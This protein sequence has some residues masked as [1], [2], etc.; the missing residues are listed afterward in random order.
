MLGRRPAETGGVSGAIL[1]VRSGREGRRRTG[2]ENKKRAYGGFVVNFHIRET[3]LHTRVYA[4]AGNQGE[5]SR[6]ILPIPT[7]SREL[8][9]GLNEHRT[10]LRHITMD[11]TMQGSLSG[12]NNTTLN[13]VH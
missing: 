6:A 12:R 10:L 9:C 11:N 5:S 3:L 8:A 13:D 1:F 2:G 4:F 7:V